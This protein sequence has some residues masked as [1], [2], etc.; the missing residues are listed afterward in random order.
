MKATECDDALN[1]WNIV[2]SH[3]A[4]VVQDEKMHPVLWV[5]KKTLSSE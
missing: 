4:R 1:M 2:E 5:K 3:L